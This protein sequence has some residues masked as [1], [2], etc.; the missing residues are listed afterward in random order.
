MAHLACFMSM[1]EEIPKIFWYFFM[2]EDCAGNKL[3][4]KQSRVATREA[5]L[6]LGALNTGQNRLPE[7]DIFRL[8]QQSIA[9]PT[10]QSSYLVTVMDLFTKGIRLL[11]SSTKILTC[12]LEDQRLLDLI[13][14][15]L[16]QNILSIMLKE[17]S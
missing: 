4:R 13:S 16:T 8:T 14:T 9:L 5:K 17:S 10:G 15:G 1:K 7:K 3:L 12:I 2:E 11:P 6:C